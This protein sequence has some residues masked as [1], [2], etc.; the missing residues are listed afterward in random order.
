AL[1]DQSL[2]VGSGERRGDGVRAAERTAR[3]GEVIDV[4]YGVAVRLVETVAAHVAPVRQERGSCN[5]IGPLGAGESRE[6]VVGAAGEAEGVRVAALQRLDPR[7]FISPEDR[8]QQ[9]APIHEL[10]A[11]ADWKLVGNIRD[12]AVIA[13]VAGASLL[14]APVLN[15]RDARTV[16]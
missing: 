7:D 9:A 6:V 4:D 13:V 1:I 11:L 2:A 5:H 16:I 8:V 12:K 3:I 14:Q 15:G 10:P